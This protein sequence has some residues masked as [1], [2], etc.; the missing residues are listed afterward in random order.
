M[1]L[2]LP[3]FIACS[4]ERSGGEPGFGT[5]HQPFSG[6]AWQLP[7]GI[8][9]TSGQVHEYSYCTGTDKGAF[10]QHQLRGVPGGV[11]KVCF[12]LTNTT[13]REILVSFPE[14]LLIQSD[15]SNYS[16]GLLIGIGNVSLAPGEVRKVYANAFC[17]NEDRAVPGAYDYSGALLSFRF[18]PSKVPAKL[19]T[20]ADL[21]RNKGLQAHQ[22]ADAQGHIDYKKLKSV[23][24]VQAAIWE[25]T[26]GGELQPATRKELQAVTAL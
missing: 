17:L 25:V 21:V 2:A 23:A 14:D 8:I 18:G 4:K 24:C 6:T 11:F 22:C 7:A 12:E 19:K 26:G 16:N 1:L 9:L 13:T 15:N 10:D 3:S 20:V 5:S